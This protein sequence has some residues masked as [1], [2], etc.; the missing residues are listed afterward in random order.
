MATTLIVLGH[1]TNASGFLNQTA[2]TQRLQA[3]G[4]DL[5]LSCDKCDVQKSGTAIVATDTGQLE[6]RPYDKSTEAGSIGISA[7][8]AQVV[9]K[10]AAVYTFSDRDAARKWYDAS[11]ADF[12]LHVAYFFDDPAAPAA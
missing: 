4:G 6:M 3:D 5:I 12:C 2:R 1:P 7:E 8:V 9:P 11:K 10:G